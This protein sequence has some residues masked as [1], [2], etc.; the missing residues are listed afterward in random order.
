MKNIDL[1]DFLNKVMLAIKTGN[2]QKMPSLLAWALS[3]LALVLTLFVAFRLISLAF[4]SKFT[5]PEV[6]APPPVLINLEGYD[7]A[8]AR[9]NFDYSK[10]SSGFNGKDPFSV[11]KTT[12][13]E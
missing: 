13:S 1:K 9:K 6:K 12:P 11:P 5:D 4:Q 10:S 2:V 3:F 7:N 8:A